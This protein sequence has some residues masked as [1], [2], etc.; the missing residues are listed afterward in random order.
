[1]SAGLSTA[2]SPSSAPAGRVGLRQTIGSVVFTVFFMLWTFCYGIFFFLAGLLLRYRQRFLL[3]RVWARVILAVLRWTCR[4]DFRVEGA[5][6]LPPG[7][8]VVLM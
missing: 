6:R 2:S 3:A 8:H 7:N 1:M 5:E 4:L